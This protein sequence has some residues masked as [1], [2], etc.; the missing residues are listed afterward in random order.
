MGVDSL[1]GLWKKDSSQEACEIVDIL[2]TECSYFKKHVQ[3]D[4]ICQLKKQIR[5][6]LYKLIL[7]F[8]IIL[9]FLSPLIFEKLF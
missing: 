6:N 7:F 1:R 5:D 9:K 2:R 4:R 3:W 8:L